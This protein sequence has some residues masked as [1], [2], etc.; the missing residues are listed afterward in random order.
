MEDTHPEDELRVMTMPATARVISE[1]SG[2]MFG[3]VVW[4]QNS[5]PMLFARSRAHVLLPDD[6]EE[7]GT[8]RVHDGDVWKEPLSVV[9]LQRVDHPQE[10]W[11]L[12]NGSHDIVRYA[13]GHGPSK[14]GGVGK[15][16]V[17]TSVTAL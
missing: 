4:H 15:Q 7:Q 8:G 10:E 3:V 9:A 5:D 1:E 2:D 6:A 12:R 14:P 11:V 16:G 17:K 13:G